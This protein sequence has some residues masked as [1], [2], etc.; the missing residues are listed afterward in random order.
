MITLSTKP[1]IV[2]DLYS[3]KYTLTN[4][5]HEVFNL[6]PNPVDGRYYGYCPARNNVNIQKLGAKRGA[7]SVSD[8]MVIYVA[9]GQGTNDREIIAFT[10]D[11]TV[12]S[13]GLAA[14]TSMQRT[15]TDKDGKPQNAAYCIESDYIYDL[16]NAANKFVIPIKAYNP[17]MF[18]K[19][20]FYKGR[21]LKLE[22]DMLAYLEAYLNN[23]PLADID[24]QNDIQDATPAAPGNYN[25]R[26]CEYVHGSNGTA[27]KKN[28]GLAKQV[29][30][31][32]T[33]QCAMDASHQTFLTRHNVPYMEGHHLI[34]CTPTNAK[35]FWDRFQRNID[36]PENIVCLC[37]T[38]HRQ[39]HFGSAAEK[40]KVIQKLYG[41]QAATL[42]SAGISITLNELLNLYI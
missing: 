40:Q 26:Q 9:K 12:H 4:K 13:P 19:Q 39:I 34:P 3:G 5:G 18:R 30:H 33:Y 25:T 23:L 42:K 38:C 28:P 17:Q 7:K 36:C 1:F 8:V 24:E 41:I 35:T 22:A 32:S 20:R 21:Y 37:P 2:I 11:A 6:T 29:L 10:D 27:V 16:R 14:P 31:N 15:F